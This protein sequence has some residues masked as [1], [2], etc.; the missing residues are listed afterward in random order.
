MKVP[1]SGKLLGSIAYK[2]LQVHHYEIAVDSYYLNGSPAPAMALTPFGLAQG[3]T[4]TTVKTNFLRALAVRPLLEVE[5]SGTTHTSS[6]KT[7]YFNAIDLQEDLSVATTGLG[8][9]RV[10]PNPVQ[11]GQLHIDVSANAGSNLNYLL[12]DVKGKP[13]LQGSLDAKGG[14]LKLPRSTAPGIYYL[15]LTN[16]EQAKT[17]VPIEVP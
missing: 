5:H 13:V 12:I 9:V 4:I 15:T 17:V 3:Q 7:V 11:D 10:Y 1:M 6:P 14:A 8:T 16:A 2:V